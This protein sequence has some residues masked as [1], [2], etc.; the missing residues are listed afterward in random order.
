MS[1]EAI[2]HIRRAEFS[3]KRALEINPRLGEAY[4]ALGYSNWII[5][6][7]PT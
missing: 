4:A 5:K 7:S 2:E 3:A 6:L 1:E